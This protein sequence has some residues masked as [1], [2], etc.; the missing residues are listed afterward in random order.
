[1]RLAILSLPFRY[2]YGHHLQAYAL[3]TTLQRMGH[4]VTIIDHEFHASN[5]WWR[6]PLSLSKRAFNR[7]VRGDKRQQIFVEHNLNVEDSL[8]ATN[9]KQFRARYLPQR[10]NI[11]S[12]EREI[13]PDMF[14]GFIVG[15]DQ[16]WRPGYF[17]WNYQ[18]SMSNAYLGFA[19][20]WDI[21][22]IAYAASFGFEDWQY[23]DE[24]TQDCAKLAQQFDAISV[25]ESS[26]VALCER[27]LGVQAQH[28]L[29]PT[30]LLEQED[31]VHIAET[32]SSKPTSGGLM[33]YILDNNVEIDKFVLNTSQALGLKP[34]AANSRVENVHAP[35]EQRIQPPITQW[36]RGF[37]DAEFVITDSFHGTV[38]CIIFNK[39]FITISNNDR[40]KARFTSLLDSF[41]LSDRLISNIDAPIATYSCIQWDSINKT[42]ILLK[43]EALKFL[44]EALR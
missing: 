3:Q 12:F 41:N 18:T 5:K 38:F 16:V 26:A 8:L 21:K 15:S 33:T 7:Y 39:P 13:K 23:N 28:V 22:R 19:H 1:M 44:A 10:L 37:M 2:N 32:D 40:G 20:D 34:F 4:D 25:R 31:Y 43:K 6:Y 14:D 29:D 35:I 17:T 11:N 9:F 36:L 30:M 24:Q 27:Y 42:R